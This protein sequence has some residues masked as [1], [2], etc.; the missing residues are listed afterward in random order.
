MDRITDFTLSP[1]GRGFT[2][3]AWG[4]LLVGSLLFLKSLTIGDPTAASPLLWQ[5]SP[6]NQSHTRIQQFFGG[7]EPL[8]VVVEGKQKKALQEPAAVDAMEGFQRYVDSD[9]EIGYSFSLA[10]IVKSI[11]MVFFDT[12]PRWGVIPEQVSRIANL[13]FFYR[14]TRDQRR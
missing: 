13:F 5:D 6:Y 7:V 4:A 11:N 8:I 3:A 12:E 2:I 9:P 10:D 1:R 14:I